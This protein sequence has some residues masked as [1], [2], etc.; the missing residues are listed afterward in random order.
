MNKHNT[1]VM[2]SIISKKQRFHL[3]NKGKDRLVLAICSLCIF[4]FLYTACAKLI[5]HGRFLNGLSHVEVIGRF[6]FFI[7]WL[8]PL[9]EILIAILLVVPRTVKWGLYSF[10]VLMTLFTVYIISMLLWASKLPCHCGGAIEKLS[11]T[12]HVWFNLA[13]IALAVFALRLLKTKD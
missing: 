1:L 13:F 4:L 6:A 11:W 7:S 12:Q 8:V 5:D 2:D 9:A 3:T 10:L